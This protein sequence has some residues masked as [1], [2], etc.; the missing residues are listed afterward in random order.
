[1]IEAASRIALAEDSAIFNGYVPG[2]IKG[3]VE[4]SPH[5]K[6]TISDDYER[7]PQTVAEATRLLRV[8]GVDGPYGIAL[9]PRCYAGVTQATERG[10]Y[11]VIELVRRV[12]DGPIV[13][14]PAVDGA[15]VLSVAGDDFELTVGQDLSIGYLSHTDTA[16]RLY[17]TETMTFRVL[18]PEAGVALVYAGKKKTST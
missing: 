7:Y 8:A 3:I 2:G 12:L 13:W 11:P 18:R 6:L 10:G 4:S 17:L 16:V 5:P 1:L 15:V 9:G 14:A